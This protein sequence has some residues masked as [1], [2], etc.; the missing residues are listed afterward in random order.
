MDCADSKEPALKAVRLSQDLPVTGRRTLIMEAISRRCLIH[1]GPLVAAAEGDTCKEELRIWCGARVALAALEA[2][3]LTAQMLAPIQST[4]LPPPARVSRSSCTSM[5]TGVALVQELLPHS[6]APPTTTSLAAVQLA[7]SG[8]LSSQT[9]PTVPTPQVSLTQLKGTKTGG[10]SEWDEQVTNAK[11]SAAC[12]DKEL[13][14]IKQ[15]N[16]DSMMNVG[17]ARGVSAN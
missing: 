13:S 17:S 7:L 6:P 5:V 16:R 1:T 10:D 9:E 8:P 14:E 2:E 11:N 4:Q 12:N 15:E 3:E